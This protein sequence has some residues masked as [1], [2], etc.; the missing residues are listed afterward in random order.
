M[1]VKNDRSFPWLTQYN[2]AHRGLF[3]E[4]TLCEENT[5]AAVAAAK[6]AGYAAEIDVR[7]S[8]DDIIMVYHD[9]TLERLTDSEGPVSKWGFK[10]LQAREIGKSGKGMPTL[11]EIMDVI[12]SDVPL[13]IELKSPSHDDIQKLCAG[14]R[15]CF[16][17]YRGPVAIMSFDPRILAWFKQYMPAYPRGAI[18]GREVLLN[19]RNRLLIP[20]WMRKT[21]PDFL[22]CD[23]N[24][25]PN[26]F[27]TRWRDKGKPVLTWTVRTQKHVEIGREHA[28]A[29][30]FEK[31]APVDA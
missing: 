18:I 16:E 20:Y 6:E 17:G 19:W 14:V 8:A 29:L 13:F 30:I 31:P 7:T 2:I 10:Q 27:C 28:D 5:V 11:P 15:H 4:G 21:K 12:D 23:I 22:A 26:S 9:D 25:L 24:L 3:E 1:A